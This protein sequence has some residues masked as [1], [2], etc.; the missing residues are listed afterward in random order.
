VV[1]K[2]LLRIFN[3]K[4]ILNLTLMIYIFSKVSKSFLENRDYLA[5]VISNHFTLI[6]I[7]VNVDHYN[8]E[9]VDK[10]ACKKS[11]TLLNSHIEYIWLK[12]L[13]RYW[14]TLL[15]KNGL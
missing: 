15:I 3:S 9:I 14:Q 11:V 12:T 8:L 6:R 7:I 5:N 1:W 2:H 13:A 10:F 4:L